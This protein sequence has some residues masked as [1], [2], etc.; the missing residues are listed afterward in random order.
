MSLMNYGLE[1]T[2]DHVSCREV[3]G[4]I[5]YLTREIY[6]LPYGSALIVVR[7]F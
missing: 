2:E 1:Q 3:C 7:I 5:K 4:D 6:N